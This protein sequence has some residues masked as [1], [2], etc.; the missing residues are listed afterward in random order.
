M[1][2]NSLRYVMWIGL[3][4]AGCD[5]GKATQPTQ[6]AKPVEAAKSADSWAAR[7]P[8]PATR[9][10]P[11]A[12][13]TDPAEDAKIEALCAAY[14]KADEAAP[15]GFKAFRAAKAEQG[16][17]GSELES[18]LTFGDGY[19][20][21]RKSG[22]KW[23]WDHY[24]KDARFATTADLKTELV[25]CDPDLAT[26]DASTNADG[27]TVLKRPGGATI[28]FSAEHGDSVLRVTQR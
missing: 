22:G 13:A 19:A 8:Q 16:E 9:S 14:M 20:Y 15:S 4:S 26:A 28:T 11:T 5:S 1:N 25:L 21:I 2:D 7:A 3:V 24:W 18:S 10:A 23:R 27:E 17:L 6:T 12:P